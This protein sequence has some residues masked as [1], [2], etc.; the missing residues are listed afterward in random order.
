[1]AKLSDSAEIARLAEELGYP[2]A[3]AEI[4]ARLQSL[5]DQPNH[6]IAVAAVEEEQTLLGWIAAEERTLL[7]AAA[8][9]EI[10]GLVVDHAARRAGIGYALIA[11]VEHWAKERG[12]EK[13]VVRSNIRRQESHPFYEGLGY[14]RA[15]SQHVYVKEQSAGRRSAGVA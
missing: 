4:S 6:F 3:P 7:I 13:I 5:L 12:L 8:Q 11:A 2:A 10:M 1:M 14:R 9:I 15:K